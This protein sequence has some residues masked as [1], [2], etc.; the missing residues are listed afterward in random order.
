MLAHLAALGLL[1]PAGPALVQEVPPARADAVDAT[2]QEEHCRVTPDGA[3]AWKATT[4]AQGPCVGFSP[5]AY[6]QALHIGGVQPFALSN[7][8]DPFLG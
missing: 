6:T 5:S 3:G 7:A 8:Q 2:L 4:P 1:A